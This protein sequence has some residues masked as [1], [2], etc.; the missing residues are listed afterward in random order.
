MRFHIEALSQQEDINSKLLD[1][2]TWG[3]FYK[4]DL[5]TYFTLST[6]FQIIIFISIILLHKQIFYAFLT[7]ILIF[8]ICLQS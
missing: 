6:D 5:D 1:S 3:S 7:V 4:E 2:S 8:N